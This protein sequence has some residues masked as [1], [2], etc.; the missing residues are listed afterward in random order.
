MWIIQI[1]QIFSHT[2]R[3]PEDGYIIISDYPVVSTMAI[4]AHLA[5]NYII[6]GYLFTCALSPSY[7]AIFHIAYGHRFNS[8]LYSSDVP[9][10]TCAHV[11]GC[12]N[13]LLQTI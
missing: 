10:C 5:M 1:H 11:H 7:Y 2:S 12:P 6:P 4:C 3:Q 9:M 8:L 13:Q